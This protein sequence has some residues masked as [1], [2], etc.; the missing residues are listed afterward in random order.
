M[1]RI[2]IKDLLDEINYSEGGDLIGGSF[3]FDVNG[4]QFQVTITP[5]INFKNSVVGIFRLINNPKK[6]EFKGDVDQYIKDKE[7]EE[8][9]DVSINASPFKIFSNVLGTFKR[10]IDKYQ[11]DRF[12]FHGRND[13]RSKFYEKLAKSLSDKCGYKIES[14]KNPNNGFTEFHLIKN[15][16]ELIKESIEFFKSWDIINE[17]N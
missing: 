8:M 15:D 17:T 12:I 9:G 13:K 7:E 5:S 10:Y 1:E 3:N 11:P 2:K 6:A 4:S 16:V 14:K